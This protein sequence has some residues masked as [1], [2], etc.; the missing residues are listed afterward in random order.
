MS[1]FSLDFKLYIISVGNHFYSWECVS[2]DSVLY[3]LIEP[4]C[5]LQ[6]FHLLPQASHKS[7]FFFTIMLFPQKPVPYNSCGCL[8][9]NSITWF[10][11][12]GITQTL[13][14][15]MSVMSKCVGSTNRSIYHTE[16]VISITFITGLNLHSRIQGLYLVLQGAFL[17]A[18][19]LL[20]LGVLC[21]FCTNHR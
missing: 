1:F 5:S 3:C 19:S 11:C 21:I 16:S 2:H 7:A 15:R 13:K 9:L 10:H 14:L 12:R 6:L 17:F 4:H 20:M 18:T 8:I